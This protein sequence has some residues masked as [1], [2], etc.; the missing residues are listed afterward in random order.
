MSQMQM[1]GFKTSGAME[2]NGIM[3]DTSFFI[4]LLNQQDA[5][6]ENVLAYYRYFLEKGHVL[7]VS[8]ISIAEY[9][10]RGNIDELPLHDIQ[11]IPFNVSHAIQAGNLA[12]FVFQKR[13]TFN[14]PDRKIIPNDTK[15]FAQADTKTQILKFAT[16]DL[17][18]IKVFNLLNEHLKLRFEIINIRIPYTETFGLLD[19]K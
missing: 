17:A 13:D 19:L 12:S 6:H 11:V 14:L 8:T 18:C 9:C 1:N 16:A 15:L 2:H 7:K 3:L 4:R 5:L 10:V